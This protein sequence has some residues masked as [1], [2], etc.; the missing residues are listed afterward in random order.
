MVEE[1][2]DFATVYTDGNTKYFTVTA[3]VKDGYISSE[4]S[5]EVTK[6][7]EKYMNSSEFKAYGNGY[8]IIFAGENEEVMDT[9]TDLV[10]AL[11]IAIVLVYM[12]M[13][14][15]FQSL[16]YP[17][18]IIGTIPLAFTGGLLALWM[19]GMQVSA[20][21]LMGLLVLV[22]VVVNNGIVLIDYINQLRNEGKELRDAIYE[23]GQTRLRPIFM[24]ALTTIFGLTTMA[25]GLENGS[26]LL[27][28]MGVVVIGGL[29][30]STV[31]T[32]FFVPVLYEALT[33][34]KKKEA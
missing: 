31:L 22:G 32:L 26:E 11:M 4:V 19:C 14:I 25:L 2:S 7:V 24:T 16:K 27:Q 3:K 29:I 18:I 10:L 9:L 17:L 33:R 28:P 5:T 34:K 23:A 1:V 13:A 30:Y 21:A 8:K 6:E 15:Q 12:V 20:V